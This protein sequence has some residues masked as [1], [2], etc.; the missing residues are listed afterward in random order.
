MNNKII[1]NNLN[2]NQFFTERDQV[3]IWLYKHKVTNYIICQDLTVD[4]E[5]NLELRNKNIT[6]LPI[7]F[8]QVAGSCDISQNKLTSLKGVPHEI[9]GHLW[10]HDNLLTNLKHFPQKIRGELQAQNNQLTNIDDIY[11]NNETSLI[12]LSNNPQIKD[13]SP[14][15]KIKSIKYLHLDKCKI[16]SLLDL[17]NIK[18]KEILSHTVNNINEAIPEIKDWYQHRTED[19]KL[20]IDAEKLNSL[21]EKAILSASLISSE[22]NNLTQIKKI[23]L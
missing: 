13:F 10:C 9:G 22:E 18:I 7:Q 3:E 15:T 23:K 16:S 14:L 8:G 4:V 2:S 1:D 5:G 12:D 6:Y 19:Y 21:I 17:K 11:F 20:I